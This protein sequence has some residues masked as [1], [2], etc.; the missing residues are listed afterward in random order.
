MDPT[1]KMAELVVQWHGKKLMGTGWD[2]QYTWAL[3]KKC[4]MPNW[5]IL[6]R[7]CEHSHKE[8]RPTGTIPSS[9]TARQ[10]FPDTVMTNQD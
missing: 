3:I 1:K 10:L 4:S 9:V 7:Q 2:I 5:K 8:T 6:A